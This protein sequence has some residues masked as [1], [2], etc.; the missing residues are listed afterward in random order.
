MSDKKDCWIKVNNNGGYT[1]HP[2]SWQYISKITVKDDE[3]V[4]KDLFDNIFKGESIQ[5]LGRVAVEMLTENP[6]SGI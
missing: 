3:V 2:I 5:F 4:I 6:S 1:I